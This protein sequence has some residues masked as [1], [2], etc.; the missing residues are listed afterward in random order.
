MSATY[1]VTAL[2]QCKDGLFAARYNFPNLGHVDCFGALDSLHISCSH[3]GTIPPRFVVQSYCRFVRAFENYVITKKTPLDQQIPF[4]SEDF[5][6]ASHED[7]SDYE[8]KF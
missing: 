8:L 6:L 3:V 1:N 4:L 7:A 2:F 5:R